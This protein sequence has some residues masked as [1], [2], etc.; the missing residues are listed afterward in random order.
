MLLGDALNKA[1]LLGDAELKKIQ[2]ED[3][4]RKRDKITQHLPALF[5]SREQVLKAAKVFRGALL[6]GTRPRMSV[7]AAL[8]LAVAYTEDRAMTES[9]IVATTKAYRRRMSE[10]MATPDGL[11]ALLF[12][13]PKVEKEA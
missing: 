10:L 3:E 7:L 9:A 2:R 11:G 12:G 1:G 4:K 8:A 6:G 13:E 5:P